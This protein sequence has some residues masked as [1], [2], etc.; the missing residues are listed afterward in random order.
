MGA[1]DIFLHVNFMFGIHKLPCYYLY[2]STDSLLWVSQVADVMS[3]RRYTDIGKYLQINENTSVAAAGQDRY[4][5]LF[6]I[7]LVINSEKHA[8]NTLFRP[9]A[10][11][12][13]F[14]GRL[15]LKQYIKGKPHPSGVIFPPRL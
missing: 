12:I 13:P 14:R 9:G 7:R 6:K 2:W 15:W 10:A 1:T 3:R 5:P 4:D 11:M 8:C